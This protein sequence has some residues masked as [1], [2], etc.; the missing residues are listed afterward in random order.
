MKMWTSKLRTSAAWIAFGASNVGCHAEPRPAQGH[1]R[2]PPPVEASHGGPVQSTA[3]DPPT[4]KGRA[5]AAAQPVEFSGA[6]SGPAEEDRWMWIRWR[7]TDREGPRRGGGYGRGTTFELINSEDDRTALYDR[8]YPN[9]LTRKECLATHESGRVYAWIYDSV[10]GS[11]TRPGVS[12]QLFRSADVACPYPNGFHFTQR[13]LAEESGKIVASFEV[14]PNMFL[15]YQFDIDRDGV[16]EAIVEWHDRVTPAI[17]SGSFGIVSLK[18]G[19]Y[20]ELY[21]GKFAVK[22]TCQKMGDLI[23][24]VALG[25]KPRA[26]GSVDVLEEL[27]QVGC[28]P[29]NITVEVGSWSLM[30]SRSMVVV[31]VPNPAP[32]P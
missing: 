1:D 29:T 17:H 22:S 28:D 16:T 13:L 24:E 32:T 4:N 11:F 12:Q 26:D 7:P 25:V 30:G 10:Q 9:R 20:R 31:G 2:T 3:P 15:G 5:V 23:H 19:K 27:W 8:I 21:K 6:T 18:G 14:S